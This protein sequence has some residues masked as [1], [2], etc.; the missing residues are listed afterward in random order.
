VPVTISMA[1]WR[2]RAEGKSASADLGLFHAAEIGPEHTPA[3]SHLL[4]VALPLWGGRRFPLPAIRFQVRFAHQF[5]FNG[6]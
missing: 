2:S 3:R 1:G 6:L 4:V 5:R